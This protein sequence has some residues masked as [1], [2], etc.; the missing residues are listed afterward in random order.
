MEYGCIGEKLGHSFSKEIHNALTD[1]DYCLK[2]LSPQEVPQ[3][4]TERSF[5]A[6]NVTI[7]YKQTVIPFLDWISDE[8]K[9]INA[10]NTIVN[11]N[12]KLYGYNTDFY[13][14]KALIERTG[15][16]LKDKKVVVLGS[17][18]TSNTAFA[19][20]N[21][22]GAKETLKVS[23]NAKD[24]Y[25]T[26]EELY[27]NHS[28]CEIVINTTPC[29]MYPK[30]GTSAVELE[31]LPNVSAV[32]DAVYNPLS[33]KLVIDAKKCGVTAV[34]GLYMLV[35]QAAYAVEKFI[36]CP[37]DAEKIEEVFKKLYKDKMNIV[38]IG[39]PASGKTSVGKML[40][41]KLCKAFVDSD[42]KIVETAGKP[43]PQIFS[44]SGEAVFRDFEKNAISDI[45]LKNSQIVA[46]GGG[47]VLKDINIEN[48]KG[49]GRV[50]FINRPLEM[51][52]ATDDRPLSSN[53]TDLEKRYKERYQLYKNSA[54]VIIDGSGT[55][56]EVEKRIEV[57]FSEYS[58]N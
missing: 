32:F 41:Q 44:D 52:I 53:K 13:G 54:D 42:E 58:C 31:K 46:T 19:V 38:L 39:M 43:I 16:S 15:A 28:D 26:Y 1:Y 3:F 24:G 20:A 55:V 33:S 30:T 36:D 14:L 22:L 50:Y 8:A 5:K 57:E 23:R 7:P 40:S 49:N 47:A 4:M 21:A 2:E 6:I 10:V 9:A 25:I 18:G 17:G 34:G 29:G 37:V 35:S 11:K 12:G 51:L 56:E 48:L 45:S 27:K